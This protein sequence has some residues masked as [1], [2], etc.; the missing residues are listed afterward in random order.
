MT[1]RELSKGFYLR[2]TM[3]QGLY[4]GHT[5]ISIHLSVLFQEKVEVGEVGAKIFIRHDVI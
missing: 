1:A 2:T 5:L 3:R 4:F